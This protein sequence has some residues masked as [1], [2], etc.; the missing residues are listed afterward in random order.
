LYGIKVFAFSQPATVSELNI[1]MYDGL[2]YQM[3]ADNI[4]YQTF[5]KD[6][7]CDTAEYT[8]QD[9]GDISVHNY[10]RI[11]SPNGTEYI[12]DGYAYI[13][14][15]AQPGKLKV[16]FNSGNAAPFDAPYWVLELGPVN[17][18]LKYD[19]AIV[20]DNLLRFLFVLARDPAYFYKVYNDNVINRLTI[21]GFT[22]NKSP[23]PTYQ[24]SDCEYEG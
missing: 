17:I 5:E 4:V 23:I 3:Y 10:A 20:S 13:K 11:G 24:G 18:E 8:I 7:Y 9:D 12:I 1:T 6:A 16:H 15:P 2:W 22:G 19:W 21:I 14:D